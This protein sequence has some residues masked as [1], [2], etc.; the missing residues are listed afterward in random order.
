MLLHFLSF[1]ERPLT[2][3]RFVG[4]LSRAV[5]P[6]VVRVWTSFRS[7]PFPCL[8]STTGLDHLQGTRPFCNLFVTIFPVNTK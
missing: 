8:Y 1:G 7:S 3:W 4:E 2:I 5:R 6:R